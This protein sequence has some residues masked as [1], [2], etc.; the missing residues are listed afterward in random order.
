MSEGWPSSESELEEMF[1]SSYYKFFMCLKLLRYLHFD[2]IEKM[3]RYMKACAAKIF[4][5]HRV[6]FENMHI[7]VRSIIRLINMV[8]IFTCITL[9]LN[10][11]KLAED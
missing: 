3:F 7:W 10:E 6:L 8:H 2:D 5:L 1:D 4:F 11:L 9:Y